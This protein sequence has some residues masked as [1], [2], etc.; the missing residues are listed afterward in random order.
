MEFYLEVLN[1]RIRLPHENNAI[2]IIICREKNRTV[3]E[4]SLKTTNHPIGVA[5][6]S[7]TSSLPEAYRNYLPDGKTIA[8]KID[9]FMEAMEKD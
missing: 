2:G 6:Y 5:T 1:D 4:Y 8:D 3:V 7:L 9:L